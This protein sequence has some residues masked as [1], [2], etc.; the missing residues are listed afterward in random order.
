VTPR[1]EAPGAGLRGPGQDIFPEMAKQSVR[2]IALIEEAAQI[3]KKESTEDGGGDFN[4]KWVP[5]GEPVDARIDAADSARSGSQVV[6]E[7]ISETTTHIITLEPGA[8]VSTS[9][10]IEIEGLVW[11]IVAE[12]IRSEQPTVRVQV[13]E[14]PA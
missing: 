4:D 7:R 12:Q 14:L 8:K 2:T 5:D 1:A 6:A 3:L 13:K 10:R 9:N 11:V